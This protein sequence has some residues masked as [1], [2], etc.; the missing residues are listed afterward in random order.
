MS[1]HSDVIPA[2]YADVLDDN[3]L[4]GESVDPV[5]RPRPLVGDEA[6][7]FQLPGGEVDGF[8]VLD[9]EMSIEAG[10]L[11]HLVR[12]IG[13]RQPLRI[14]QQLLDAVVQRRDRAQRA[15]DGRAFGHVAAGEKGQRA[16]AQ[17]AAQ[18]LAAAGVGDEPAVF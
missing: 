12:R 9:L 2:L 10:R 18:Q 7:E 4:F 1:M 16:E 15:L 11:H 13:A 17:R 3:F 6:G 14:E 8:Q 5:E